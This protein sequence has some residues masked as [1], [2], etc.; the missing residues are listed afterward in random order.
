MRKEK[1]EIKDFDEIVDVIRNCD[2]LRIGIHDDPYP[3]VVPVSFGF[4]VKNQQVIFY[5]H[6]AKEGYKHDLLKQDHHVCVEGDICYRFKDTITSVTCLFESF[7]GFG[8]ATLVE[9]KEAKK[10]LELLMEHCGYQDHV[11]NDKA[12]AYTGIYKIVINDIT[13]KRNF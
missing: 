5:F 1:R 10:G 9:G 13:G 3:Y 6:G 11:I 2:T 8:T 12:I 7:I 4:E